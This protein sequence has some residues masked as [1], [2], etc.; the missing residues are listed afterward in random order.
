MV[1]SCRAGGVQQ[2]I[3]AAARSSCLL[4]FLEEPLRRQ[5]TRVMPSPHPFH[6]DRER[7]DTRIAGAGAVAAGGRE[8]DGLPL[9]V[10]ED[11]DE[12]DSVEPLLDLLRRCVAKVAMRS[13]MPWL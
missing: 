9:V 1:S 13:S 12:M 2:L 4:R 7:G 6:I 11:D 5:A 8:R 10:L 3:D